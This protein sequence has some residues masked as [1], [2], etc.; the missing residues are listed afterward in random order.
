MVRV[1]FAPTRPRGI[2]E[3]YSGTIERS[4][5]G[6][7]II[8][9]PGFEPA[10]VF[11]FAVG[12]LVVGDIWSNGVDNGTFHRCIRSRITQGDVVREDALSIYILDS[13]GNELTGY[14]SAVSAQGFTITWELMGACTA[15]VV[16][17]AM[18]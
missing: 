1:G 10:I 7:E 8:A 16:Y 13:A 15:R 4:A 5:G 18:R 17:V 12:S 9:A 11:F 14:I 2:A 6:D 3:V